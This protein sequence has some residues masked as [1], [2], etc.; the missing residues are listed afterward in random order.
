MQGHRDWYISGPYDAQRVL[1]DFT[2][3]N[4]G[5]VP[6]M[7]MYVSLACMITRYPPS[8]MGLYHA[9]RNFVNNGSTIN[10]LQLP[11]GSSD[12]ANPKEVKLPPS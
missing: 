12:T 3:A 8:I 4:V 10:Q 7:W 2:F 1:D 5:G 6:A 9:P 11:T